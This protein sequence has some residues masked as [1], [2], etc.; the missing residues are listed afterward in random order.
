MPENMAES[1]SGMPVFF[2]ESNLQPTRHINNIYI[3]YYLNK[4]VGD[5]TARPVHLPVFD[6]TMHV[7]HPTTQNIVKFT[8]FD[9]FD[10]FGTVRKELEDRL[11]FKNLHWKPAHE[12][13]RTIHSLPVKIVGETDDYSDPNTSR[14]P[15]I[16][17]LVLSCASIDE[18]RAKVRPLVR[19]WLPSPT[20]GFNQHDE[21]TMPIKRIALLHSNSDISE[22]N[23]FKTVSFFDKFCK[24]FPSLTAI[25][26]KSIYKSEK[27]KAEFWSSTMTQ[28][29][30]YTMDIFGRR[31]KF[32]EKE[33]V[34]I[35][36]ENTILRATLQEKSLDL[37]CSFHLNEEASRELENLRT[38]LFSKLAPTISTGELEIPFPFT[39]NEI[40]AT[41]KPIAQQIATEN[42]TS[43]DLNKFFFLRH[44]DLIRNSYEQA[45]RNVRVYQLTK[46]FLRTIRQV[47][48]QSPRLAEFK[49]FF[50]NSVLAFAL[51]REDTATFHEIKADLKIIQRD[52]WM[53]LAFASHG[54]KI[55]GRQYQMMAQAPQA[56]EVRAT[57]KDEETFHQNFFTLTKEI[58]TLLGARSSK[59]YRT[60][61]LY[62]V[63]IGLLH[64]QRK[65]YEK[66][67]SMLQSCH[68][69]YKATNW[70]AIALYLLECFVDCLAKCPEIESVTMCEEAIP[71][72]TVLSNSILD[73][74]TSAKKETLKVYWWDRFLDVSGR[75]K[76]SLIYP[77][78]NT[79]DIEVGKKL[80]VTR[81]NMFSLG[82]KVHSGKIPREFCV[83]SVVLLLKNNQ[84]EFVTFEKNNVTLQPGEN[85]IALDCV[86]VLF[87]SFALVSLEFTIGNTIFCQEFLDDDEK[88]I[89]LERPIDSRNFEVTINPAKQVQVTKNSL[90]LGFFNSDDIKTFKLILTALPLENNSKETAAFNNEGTQFSKTI[91]T[92]S[93]SDIEYFVPHSCEKFTFQQELIFTFQDCPGI[94]FYQR[95]TKTVSCMLP[96][97]VLV[98]DITREGSFFFKFLVS[99][100]SLLEPVLLHKS[101]LT[102]HCASTYD[103]QGSF[104]PEVP[105]MVKSGEENTCYFFFQVRTKCE[106]LFDTKDSFQL[107]IQFSTLRNQLDHL[108]TNAILIQGNPHI[109]VKMDSHRDL[110]NSMILRKLTYDY[111]LFERKLNLQV[112]T[113]ADSINELKRVLK[114]KVQD[115]EFLEA[116]SRCL[117]A[118]KNGVVFSHLEL[119]EYT[120]DLTPDSFLVNVTVPPLPYY[121]SV[122]LEPNSPIQCNPA[123][124]QIIEYTLRATDVSKGWQKED[125]PA[126]EFVLELFNTNEWLVDGKRRFHLQPSLEEYSI[127]MIPL[128]RGYLKFPKIE[129][130]TDGRKVSEVHYLNM[131]EVTLVI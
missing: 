77:L 94:E 59:K 58:I 1:K 102:T 9:P 95:N 78:G 55:I 21:K 97:T 2:C 22:T 39:S 26:I 16:M 45:A 73:L 72:P 128:R 129:I 76:G 118:L 88:D 79:F 67:I 120:R 104:E 81:A 3:I 89:E 111:D 106:Q 109:A 29:R 44:C 40:K 71:S 70:D 110:W 61:D 43:Y 80:F 93:V 66:A 114:S 15:V 57:F 85:S 99:S 52:C 34:K 27:Q 125:R 18:Y 53:D 37:F 123:V 124:G 75:D 38:T 56:E 7:E 47:F 119:V 122:S 31:L 30:K 84:D 48:S 36:D 112:K 19:Q 17:F 24:D 74:L 68:E 46:S 98:E 6:G 117:H 12:S 62:S 23:L 91:D 115:D 127:S 60:V 90:A 51:Y 10:V 42:L 101:E 25:E 20:D 108:A 33:L 100:S 8:Y 11:P 49:F 35:T 50:I 69:Y 41:D 54:F 121:F 32:L 126:T 116:S 83:E 131:H 64:Y 13:L 14:R 87:G 130:T 28:L 92:F 4:H 82:L 96:L 105:V 113:S 65:E 103:V 63:E 5:E 107:K 86:R